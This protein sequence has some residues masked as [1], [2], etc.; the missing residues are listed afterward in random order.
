MTFPNTKY[1]IFFSI[2]ILTFFL[3][4]VEIKTV[5]KF[6]VNKNNLRNKSTNVL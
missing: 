3:Y 6:S 1:N 5:A 2:F 4:F